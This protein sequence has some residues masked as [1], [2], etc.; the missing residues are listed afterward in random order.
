MN[1]QVT[2][3]ESPKYMP[4][5][6]TARV[7]WAVLLSE[8]WEDVRI[9]KYVPKETIVFSGKFEGLNREHSVDLTWA[10]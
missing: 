7:V 9:T 2:L 5:D 1:K 8:G 4:I 6:P 10:F 3:L